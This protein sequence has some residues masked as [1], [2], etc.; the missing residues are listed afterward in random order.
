MT[1]VFISVVFVGLYAFNHAGISQ[2]ARESFNFILFLMIASALALVLLS[3]VA[4][5]GPNLLKLLQ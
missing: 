2:R 5:G 4:P 3:L 1:L